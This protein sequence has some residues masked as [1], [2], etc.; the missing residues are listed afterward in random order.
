MFLKTYNL[1]IIL[2]WAETDVVVGIVGIV[3][4]IARSIGII[5]ITS[6]INARIAGIARVF[7]LP[8]YF[9]YLLYFF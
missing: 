9:Y 1:E 8:Q 6:T 3:V 5:V 4:T 2:E 7:D